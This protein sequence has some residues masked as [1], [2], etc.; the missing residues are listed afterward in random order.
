MCTAGE[1][2]KVKVKVISGL[3]NTT[4]KPNSLKVIVRKSYNAIRVSVNC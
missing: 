1:D 4:N 3:I 2:R